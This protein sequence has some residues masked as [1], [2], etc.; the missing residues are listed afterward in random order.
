[1]TSPTNRPIAVAISDIH[2]NLQTLEVA[3]KCL[4]MAV[5]KANE[6][7]V[8][9]VV[10]GDLH[11][12]K[13]NLRGECVKAI[14]NTFKTAKRPP[15]VL[16]GNHDLI[17]E[18]S[19]DHSLNCIEDLVLIVNRPLSPKQREFIDPELGHL[20]PYQ[21][22]PEKMRAILNNI[23]IGSHLII[24]Q[25]RAGAL[26]GGYSF[27]KSALPASVY[28]PFRTFSGHYHEHQVFDDGNFVFIG[29]PYTL[30]AAEAG[31]PAKGF[32]IINEDFSFEHIPTNVRKHR[33]IT[34]N[35]SDFDKAEKIVGRPDDIVLV[36][37]IGPQRELLKIKKLVVKEQLGL[38]QDF[39]LDL[40]P[41][42]PAVQPKALDNHT[43]TQIFNAII[44]NDTNISDDT[45]EA[46]KMLWLEYV[47]C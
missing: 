35:L 15:Y 13:A 34:L 19:D 10:S 44:D 14:R 4:R 37:L 23:E 36:K 16:I 11:D 45:K 25:G 21:H 47:K 7:G 30:G 39:R 12:T 28:K 17:N 27:D 5:D 42:D 8:P 31:H 9:L 40:V 1:M 24:H 26:A 29:N 22:D 20:I 43:A 32:V 33:V 46:V 3:D 38:V 41:T 18:K 2:Y 6:L